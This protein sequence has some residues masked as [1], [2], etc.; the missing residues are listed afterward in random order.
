MIKV[1]CVLSSYLIESS[2]WSNWSSNHTGSSV[3]MF[4]R[5][6]PYNKRWTY[7]VG[8]FARSRA[9]THF[10]ASYHRLL[11]AKRMDCLKKV[12]S[13][14]RELWT[15]TYKESAREGNGQRAYP[16]H[17]YKTDTGECTA[18][19]GA[20]RDDQ[21]FSASPPYPLPHLI[22]PSLLNYTL[23]LPFNPTGISRGVWTHHPLKNEEP[24]PNNESLPGARCLSNLEGSCFPVYYFLLRIHA[25]GGNPCADPST[26]PFIFRKP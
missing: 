3:A 21:P 8:L 22:S 1:Q 10:L 24:S 15:R 26:S 7:L 18:D 4:P 19:M 6:E 2:D 12:W 14:G 25:S 23:F 20:L 16:Y 13:T 17:I 9:C 5:V 11:R